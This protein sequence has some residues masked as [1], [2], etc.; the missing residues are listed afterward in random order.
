[1]KKQFLDE[2]DVIQ[3]CHHCVKV[4]AS[5]EHVLEKDVQSLATVAVRPA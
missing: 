3:R 5:S 2:V 4:A 1:M